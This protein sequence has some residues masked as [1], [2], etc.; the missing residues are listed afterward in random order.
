MKTE[1]EWEVYEMQVFG[2]KPY[3]Y[4]WECIHCGL[5]LNDG[6]EAPTLYCED[7]GE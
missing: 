2:K 4:K 6:E 3:V 5:T 1:H 7:E